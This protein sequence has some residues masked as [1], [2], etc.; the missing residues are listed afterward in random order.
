[1]SPSCSTVYLSIL[2]PLKYL[3]QH[4]LLSSPSVTKL[5]QVPDPNSVES[6]LTFLYLSN[7]YVEDNE[8][9]S[10][11]I[12]FVGYLINV[13]LQIVYLF[14]VLHG[15]LSTMEYVLNKMAIEK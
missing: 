6:S 5:F 14:C 4:N 15:Y 3:A 2:W 10:G 8:L 9:G 11:S 1:M 13:G 7:F 12:T